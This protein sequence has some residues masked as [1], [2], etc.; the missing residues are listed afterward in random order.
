MADRTEFDPVVGGIN[1]S[2]LKGDLNSADPTY[3][4]GDNSDGR[5]YKLTMNDV[6][7]ATK[8]IAAGG[9]GADSVWVNPWGQN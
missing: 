9:V 4:F 1:P 7:F 3:D 2:A 6:I 5:M 8:Q